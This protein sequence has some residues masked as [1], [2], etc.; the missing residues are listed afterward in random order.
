MMPVAMVGREAELA[1]LRDAWCRVT[2]GPAGVRTVV[3]TGDAGTGKSLLVAS[4]LEAVSPRPA[5]I[6]AGRARVHSPAP[7]DWLAGALSG[8][9]LAEL[10]VPPD[11]LAW[12]VQHPDAPR[13]RYAPG[14]LLRLAVRA[15]RALVATGPAVL[16]VEDLHA[17]DP[18]S[19]NLVGELGLAPGLPA[20]LLVTSRPARESVAPELTARTLARLA[21]APGGVRQHLGPLDA[22]AV[23]A[24]LGQVY[25]DQPVPADVVAAVY[26]RTGGNPYRLTELLAAAG[27]AGP[28][29]LAPSP[30]ADLTAREVEVLTC[31]AAGMSN[32]QVARTLS[33]SIRTVGV[34]VSSLLRKTRSASRT[35]AALWA[36]RHLPRREV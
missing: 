20:L 35:E 33:I 13:E 25:P 2:G 24:V 36:V 22:R 9:D 8:R 5:T 27:R 14:A 23:G 26:D 32:K 31:L 12:L 10:S 28:G 3:I 16:V 15:V 6:L 19:L 17:L 29:A 4:A 11:A 1:E 21:G 34:H 7:Y 18:A 30:T